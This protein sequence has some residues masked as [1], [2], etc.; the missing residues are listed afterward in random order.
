MTKYLSWINHFS[1]ILLFCAW[2]CLLSLFSLISLLLDNCCCFSPMWCLLSELI[3]LTW[4][5]LTHRSSSELVLF[6]VFSSCCREICQAVLVYFDGRREARKL[7]PASSPI[8]HVN[9]CINALDTDIA[10]LD[11]SSLLNSDKYIGK[12]SRFSDNV[13][14]YSCYFSKIF[15]GDGYELSKRRIFSR[16]RW[17]FSDITKYE[18]KMIVSK[19]VRDDL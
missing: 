5:S 10:S 4:I 19:P 9:I 6:I 15:D 1:I 13:Q 17:Y 12:S 11:D 14:A 2:S 16:H 3:E 8:V 18:D 7:D